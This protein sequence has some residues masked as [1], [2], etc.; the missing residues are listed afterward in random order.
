MAQAQHK[1]QT[2]SP[3]QGRA[4]PALALLLPAA[5]PWCLPHRKAALSLADGHGASNGANTTGMDPIST[6]RESEN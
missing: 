1:L 2:H 4:A 3:V 6:L 5:P